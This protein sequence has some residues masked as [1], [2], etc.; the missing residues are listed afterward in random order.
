MY[1]NI[2]N[3]L[4]YQKSSLGPWLDSWYMVSYKALDSGST[5]SGS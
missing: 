5:L 4:Q 3:K 2:R 1:L